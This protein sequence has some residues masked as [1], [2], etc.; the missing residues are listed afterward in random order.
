[1][2]ANDIKEENKIFIFIKLTTILVCSF[3]LINVINYNMMG[4]YLTCLLCPVSRVT[5]SEPLIQFTVIK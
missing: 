5:F 1:M 2:E 4:F 3:L